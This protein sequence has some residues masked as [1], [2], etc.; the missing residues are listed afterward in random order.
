MGVPAVPATQRAAG[1]YSDQ[2]FEI[3]EAMRLAPCVLILL[4]S[5]A[6]GQR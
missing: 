3:F 4:M 5:A 2:R 6:M 1:N